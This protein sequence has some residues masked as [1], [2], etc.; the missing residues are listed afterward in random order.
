MSTDE[1]DHAEQEA[2]SVG[3]EANLDRPREDVMAEVVVLGAG[4][5]GTIM[6]YE[7][8]PQLRHGDKLTLIGQGPRYHFVPSNPW[9]AIGWRERS[10]IEVDL[11]SVMRR[12]GILFLEKGA[13]RVHPEENRIELGDGSSV[14]CDYLVIAT[15]PDLAF[16]EVPGLGPNGHTQSICHVD[17]AVKAKD[18]FDRFV[19]SPG[20]IVVGAAQG[21]SCFGPAYEFVFILD[22]EL[23]KRRIRDRVPMT[24]VTAEPY[25]GHLGLDGV[26]DTQGLLESELRERHIKWITSA[27]VKAVEAGKMKVAEV[28]E[29]GNGRK[30]H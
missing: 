26:G 12:K 1:P 10:D 18:A 13:R 4:L 29:D 24:F 8:V 22:T 19:L 9:V 5:S 28:G 25:I 21:A 27:R 30:T 6:A 23:R 20:P 7:L 15:G 11:E 3:S 16:D 17:H 2:Q 14:H